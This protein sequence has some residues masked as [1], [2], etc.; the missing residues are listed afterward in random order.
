M[1]AATADPKQFTLQ[2]VIASNM[3]PSFPIGPDAARIGL[4]LYGS[5]SQKIVSDLN[6]HNSADGVKSKLI[7]LENLP[8]NDYV[9]FDSITPSLERSVRDAVRVLYTSSSGARND[10]KKRVVL[11]A[12]S[13]MYIP[14]DT[15][16]KPL[17][18]RDIQVIMMKLAPFSSSSTPSEN[19][20]DGEEKEKGIKV[21]DPQT[22]TP[23]TSSPS[24]SSS[25][26]TKKPK[27]TTV[28]IDI[29]PIGST[30]NVDDNLRGNG[31]DDIINAIKPGMYISILPKYYINF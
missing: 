13:S 21:G 28:V 27:P 3:L 19:G 22:T 14:T 5:R 8:T 31:L 2:K 11:F 29:T 7:N 26:G 9:T 24:S 23:T 25:E 16:F 18:E 12:P 1:M 30:I 17:V 15:L 10:A 4:I 20:P 6:D